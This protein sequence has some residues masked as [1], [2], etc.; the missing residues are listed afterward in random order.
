LRKFRG[1][2]EKGRDVGELKLIRYKAIDLSNAVV[3]SNY[4]LPHSLSGVSFRSGKLGPRK[5][6][7]L[8]TRGPSS[9]ARIIWV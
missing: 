1:L 6:T 3:L 8:F 5:W 2:K 7:L 9:E 4:F